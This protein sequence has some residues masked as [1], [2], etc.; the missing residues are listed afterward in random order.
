[1]PE[2]VAGAGTENVVSGVTSPRSVFEAS[3]PSAVYGCP[4]LPPTVALEGLRVIEERPGGTTSSAAVPV[5]P[6]SFPVTV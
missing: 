4:T 5:T 6:P 2:Q 1:L 3:Y